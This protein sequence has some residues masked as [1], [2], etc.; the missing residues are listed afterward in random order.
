MQLTTGDIADRLQGTLRGDSKVPI[1]GVASA[2]EAVPGQIAFA[3]DRR[4][5]QD[6]LEGGASAIVVGESYENA[7]KVLIQVANVRVGLAQLLELFHPEETFP[8][9][10][11]VSTVAASSAQID[12]T[13]SI[14]PG[15]FIGPGC[16]IGPKAVL[17]GG[18]HLGANCQVGAESRLFP[19]VVLYADT[20]LG[21]R[22]RIQAG[23]IIGSDGYGYVFD[24]EKHQKIPQIGG[25]LI[26]DDVELGA[27]VTV[28]RGAF[29][30]TVIGKGAKIDNL[31]QIAHNVV[32]G[33]HCVIVAQTGVAGST[34]I[35][36]HAIIAGQVGIAGHLKIGNK[37]VIA[38]QSGVMRD[39]PDGQKV[40]G[41]PAQGDRE[42]KRQL[43]ALRQLPD[44]L[45]RFRQLEKQLGNLK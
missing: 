27:N 3:E 14:G 34:T 30:N 39:V 35:G 45:K 32:I 24:G 41:S 7:D 33:K 36:D 44:L 20:V 2:K 19:N 43:L 5:F 15:C 11:H 31:V 17:Y 4:L 9:G 8:A 16:S 25:V 23:S 18:N 37:A 10:M 42:V 28:D 6:A 26:E 22:V 21:R 29:G 40:F 38:A 1:V 12:P 13:A